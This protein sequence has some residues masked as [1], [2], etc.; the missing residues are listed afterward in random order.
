MHMLEAQ[1][2]HGILSLKYPIVGHDLT[3]SLIKILTE[4]GYSF[5]M[6][7]E[8][9][10]VQDE[11]DKVGDQIRRRQDQRSI[12]RSHALIAMDYDAKP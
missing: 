11:K 4:R 6:T 5:T 9:E 8:C 12:H 3:D 1:P 7:V 10:I 2:K